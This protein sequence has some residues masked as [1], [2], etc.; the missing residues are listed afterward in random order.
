MENLELL[1]VVVLKQR[2]LDIKYNYPLRGEFRAVI[3]SRFKPAY[4]RNR[5]QLS[6]RMRIYRP[7]R[8]SFKAELDIEYNASPTGNSA[9]VIS[10]LPLHS[11][12]FLGFIFLPKHKVTCFVMSGSDFCDLINLVSHCD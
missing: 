9:F 11:A 8:F 7:H 10:A 5:I 2:R 6:P 1:L 4:V 12:S 3:G